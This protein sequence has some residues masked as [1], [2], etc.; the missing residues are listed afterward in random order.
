M[1]DLKRLRARKKLLQKEL[2]NA[3][4]IAPPY[5][6]MI[7]AKKRTPSIKIVKKLAQIL[8][9]PW[10]DFFSEEDTNKTID[11]KAKRKEK[12]LTIDEVCLLTN[13]KRKDYLAIENG[14]KEPNEDELRVLK[15]IFN[16]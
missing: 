12:D 2:A 5:Y 1:I 10:E 8:D 6:S 15:M 9:F 13:I 14:Q 4:G 7:E 3:V 11:F 16:L